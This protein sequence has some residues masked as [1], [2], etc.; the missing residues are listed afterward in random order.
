[1]G[2]HPGPDPR[3]SALL[4]RNPGKER[5]I[6]SGLRLQFGHTAESQTDCGHYCYRPCTFP[7]ARAKNKLAPNATRNAGTAV[8]S[9]QMPSDSSR[10]RAC[11]FVDPEYNEWMFAPTASPN[12]PSATANATCRAAE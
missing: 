8:I 3:S 5:I 4:G 1:M 7:S 2:K 12:A 9:G 10:S 6:T 11:W